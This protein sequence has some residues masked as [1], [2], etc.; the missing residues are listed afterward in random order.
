MEAHHRRDLSVA[1]AD[2]LDKTFILLDAAA[3]HISVR[4]LIAQRGADAGLA[5]GS[6]MQL[7]T[8]R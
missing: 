1:F 2:L 8:R 4:N 6:V 7:P 5:D 3:Q